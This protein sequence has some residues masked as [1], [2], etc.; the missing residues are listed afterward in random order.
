MCSFDGD[1]KELSNEGAGELDGNGSQL[2]IEKVV[3]I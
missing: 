1:F 2:N 3:N